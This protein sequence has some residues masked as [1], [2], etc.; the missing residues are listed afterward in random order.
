MFFRP[1][2]MALTL[3]AL[4][5]I[6]YTS[7]WSRFH[8][9]P[10]LEYVEQCCQL[11]ASYL[12]NFFMSSRSKVAVVVSSMIYDFARAIDTMAMA[13]RRQEDG[14]NKKPMHRR[15]G[16]MVASSSH[17]CCDRAFTQSTTESRH[18]KSSFS[19]WIFVFYFCQNTTP[20]CNDTICAVR[21]DKSSDSSAGY[22]VLIMF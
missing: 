3:T 7:D 22:C 15:L 21:F 4:F 11:K 13:N 12:S 17:H 1:C 19:W 20:H 18:G 6:I 16:D 14:D 2:W 5:Y 9:H 8:R 10:I